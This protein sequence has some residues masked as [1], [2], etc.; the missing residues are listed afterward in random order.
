MQVFNDICRVTRHILFSA[1]TSLPRYNAL[2]PIISI[3]AVPNNYV[4]IT[5]RPN[6][7]YWTN[8]FVKYYE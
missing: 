7:E 5:I 8:H 3:K 6:T 1:L 4:I 2:A